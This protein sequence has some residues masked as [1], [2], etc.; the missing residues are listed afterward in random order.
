MR[1]TKDYLSCRVRRPHALRDLVALLPLHHCDVV[2]ALQ[3]EPELRSVAE[4]AP[5]AHGCIGRDRAAAVENVGDTAGRYTDVERQAI[6]GKLTGCKFATGVCERSY[7][8]QPLLHPPHPEE[9][10]KPASRRVSGPGPHASRRPLRGLLS[11][12]KSAGL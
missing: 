9:R 8:V 7:D 5:Q 1:A 12:R 2:L 3:V 4:I 10:A 11:M 6:G